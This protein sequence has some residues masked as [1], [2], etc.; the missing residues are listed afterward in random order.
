MPGAGRCCG[1]ALA[2]RPL[3]GVVVDTGGFVLCPQQGVRG[4]CAVDSCDEAMRVQAAAG[5]ERERRVGEQMGVG[6]R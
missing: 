6:E 5:S 2:S 3:A 1:G 4:G